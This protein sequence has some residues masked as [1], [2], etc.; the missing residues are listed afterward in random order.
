[1]LISCKKKHEIKCPLF[2]DTWI[3][4]WVLNLTNISS[5]H[6]VTLWR[7][8]VPSA[9]VWNTYCT[10]CCVTLCFITLCMLLTSWNL[11]LCHM[12]FHPIT[13]IMKSWPVL[14]QEVTLTWPNIVQR[15]TTYQVVVHCIL[16]P[17]CPNRGYWKRTRH[18]AIY[19]TW[20]YDWELKSLMFPACVCHTWKCTI[21]SFKQLKVQNY[22]CV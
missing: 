16:S 3:V 5:E 14:S 9:T 4:N 15:S 7:I 1:M 17:E 11:I 21:M 6:R 13:H 18:N 10:V 2:K 22:P 20:H 8:V 19:M 12:T